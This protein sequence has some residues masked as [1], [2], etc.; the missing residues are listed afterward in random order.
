MA[1][2]LKT[3]QT[4][5]VEI[6]EDLVVFFQNYYQKTTAKSAIIEALQHSRKLDL[7]TLEKALISRSD[8]F[9]VDSL[10][11][12]QLCFYSGQ[13]DWRSVVSQLVLAYLIP[14]YKQHQQEIKDEENS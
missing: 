13:S 2:P 1:R 7:N 3:K 9:L 12:Y 5:S 4:I 10:T 8:S 14:F 6:P 11:Q